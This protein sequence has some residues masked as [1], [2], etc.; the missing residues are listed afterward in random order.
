M[1]E[2]GAVGNEYTRCGQRLVRSGGGR[3]GFLSV[4]DR[5][6]NFPSGEYEA[7]P[8]SGFTRR[9]FEY[10]SGTLSASQLRRF[11]LTPEALPRLC[12][13]RKEIDSYAGMATLKLC[14]KGEG[15]NQRMRLVAA[16][17]SMPYPEGGESLQLSALDNRLTVAARI[18][19][20]STLLLGAILLLDVKDQRKM[21]SRLLRMA[22]SAPDDFL[23]EI[24]A[25][26]C[27]KLRY[28]NQVNI[29]S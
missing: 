16:M 7:A 23:A 24:F 10:L 18:L 25:K 22:E 13:I 28:L 14:L 8:R 4:A 21:P 1:I 20:C 6:G 5:G 17:L 19:K 15:D 29:S 2:T 27:A 12:E 26:T 9:S 11:D 3:G